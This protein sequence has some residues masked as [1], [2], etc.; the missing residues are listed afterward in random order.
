MAEKL[1]VFLTKKHNFVPKQ[2]NLR[3]I[4]SKNDMTQS[5]GT[6]KILAGFGVIAI[7][8]VILVASGIVPLTSLQVKPTQQ[9]GY[10]GQLQQL[11]PPP[12]PPS[13]STA[14]P[15]FAGTIQITLNEKDVLNPATSLTEG[16]NISTL[17][18][19]LNSDGTTY[20]TV[21][22]GSTTAFNV[23]IDSSF[24][25]KLYIVEQIPSGQSYFIAPNAMTDK[26][27]NPRV[28]G[29]DFKDVTGDGIPEW[30][31]T[32]DLTGIG[33]QAISTTSGSIVVPVV[34]MTWNVM[35]YGQ[36][37]PTMNSPA[38]IFNVSTNANTQTFIQWQEIEAADKATADYQL[39][40]NINDTNVG[41]W[42]A[43]QTVLTIP[44][45][46]NKALTA[47]TM[48]QDGTKTY[49]RLPLGDQTLHF[50]NYV[51]TPNNGNTVHQ[52]PVQF[53]SNLVSGH[54]SVT[55]KIYYITAG[56]GTNSVSDTV[57][58]ST[59]ASGTC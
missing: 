12:A 54:Y 23:N 14:T 33:A 4:Y 22:T 50:A 58:V 17:I 11:P 18:M 24:N 19:K 59:A 41:H 52:F 34:P 21:A 27:L 40:L 57:C 3:P 38:D 26:N 31:F 28:I 51:A 55:L 16:T 5:S 2:R 30:I 53:T 36:Q 47:F 37:A 43:G 32:V 29:A 25:N 35:A 45:I 42:N 1:T 6:M 10:S 15:P 20:S 9:N 56:Q 8:S 44:N 46:G 48:S 49:Y 13:G 7:V 39:E